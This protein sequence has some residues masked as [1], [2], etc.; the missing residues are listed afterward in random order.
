MSKAG[1]WGASAALVLLAAAAVTGVLWALHQRRAKDPLV[2]LR[3]A[4]GRPV[5]LVNVGT[6][7]IGF[8]FYTNTLATAQLV[9]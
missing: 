2:N 1:D 9:Q 4:A 8:A 7:F 5:L 3:L 6:L